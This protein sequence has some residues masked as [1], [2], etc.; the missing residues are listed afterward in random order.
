MQAS[1]LVIFSRITRCLE[2]QKDTD[3]LRHLAPQNTCGFRLKPI[4]EH[5]HYGTWYQSTIKQ[6]TFSK[7]DPGALH[8]LHRVESLSEANEAHQQN[9]ILAA[10]W[11]TAFL[12][13]AVI[14]YFGFII[15][16]FLEDWHMKLYFWKPESHSCW[17][18]LLIQQVAFQAPVQLWY[19]KP[20]HWQTFTHKHLL[21]ILRIYIL[22]LNV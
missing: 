1:L 15:L 6:N 19:Q 21:K 12:R 11:F 22:D 14:F 20:K 10:A 8:T 9:G 18:L 2:I 17:E 7:L 5:R 13:W 16:P 4:K 3:A